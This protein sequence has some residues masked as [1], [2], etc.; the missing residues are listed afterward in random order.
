V[1]PPHGSPAPVG[2]FLRS[3]PHGVEGTREGP[4]NREPRLAIRESRFA[5]PLG[6]VVILDRLPDGFAPPPTGGGTA[7]PSGRRSRI[8]SASLTGCPP[9]QGGE[10]R[11]F[12]DLRSHIYGSEPTKIRRRSPPSRVRPNSEANANYVGF[13]KSERLCDM[14]PSHFICGL[15]GPRT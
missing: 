13:D 15:S 6:G 11:N 8:P 1:R 14:L 7:N 12:C 2:R 3:A 4:F 10:A 9:P 5:P